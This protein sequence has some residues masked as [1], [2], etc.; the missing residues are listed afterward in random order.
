MSWKKM[1]LAG[2]EEPVVP[3]VSLVV[4]PAV[5]DVDVVEVEVVDVDVVDVDVVEVDVVE[6]AEVPPP[7]P[8]P[9]P[10]PSIAANRATMPRVTICGRFSPKRLKRWF[11][12]P[13]SNWDAQTAP[14]VLTR[15]YRLL[16]SVMGK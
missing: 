13:Y 14:K 8:P 9:P 4:E 15:H 16:V 11:R 6:V 1:R 7:P 12:I 5:V 2:S 10:Q 3:V